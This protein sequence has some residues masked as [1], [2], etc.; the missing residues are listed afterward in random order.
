MS[1]RRYAQAALGHLTPPRT[2]LTF[3]APRRLVCSAPLRSAHCRVG[4][5]R[6]LSIP[7]VIAAT[8]HF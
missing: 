3:F 4:D 8:L 5:T 2:V 6:I 1:R 7:G